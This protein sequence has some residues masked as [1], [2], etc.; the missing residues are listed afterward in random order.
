MET[1]HRFGRIITCVVVAVLLYGISLAAPRPQ[2]GASNDQ[3]NTSTV[4]TADSESTLPGGA[5]SLQETHGDWR[6]TCSQ[7][8]EKV[9]SLSQQQVSAE[10]RQRIIVV[11][12]KATDPDKVEGTLVMPFGLLLDAG[13]TLQID[14]NGKPWSLRFRTCLPAGCLV[15][16]AFD[17]ETL[18]AL[19]KGKSLKVGATA[20]SGQEAMFGI[21]LNGFSGALDRTVVL[22]N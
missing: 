12:L 2:A 4:R 17:K 3:G 8:S 20:H 14:D 11:E 5:T 7:Q 15:P 6:V 1:F 10:N 19:R 18:A 9:C 22:S 13:I 16:L 21:S